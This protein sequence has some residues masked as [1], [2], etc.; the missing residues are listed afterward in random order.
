[1]DEMEGRVDQELFTKLGKDA[2]Y[3]AHWLAVASP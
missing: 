3:P 1:V 2:R